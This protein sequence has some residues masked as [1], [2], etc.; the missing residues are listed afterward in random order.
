MGD[1]SESY[2]RPGR[3]RA[4]Q[5]ISQRASLL[6]PFL[7][8]AEQLPRPQTNHSSDRTGNIR[9]DKG[10]Q[11]HAVQF[12]QPDSRDTRQIPRN[13]IGDQGR[14]G[15]GSA[16]RWNDKQQD[17]SNNRYTIDLI[18]SLSSSPPPQIALSIIGGGIRHF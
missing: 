4:V 10:N 13:G 15:P 17:C 11:Q 9:D 8:P 12:Q 6:A 2:S 3:G 7:R 18:Y 1:S 5:A 14:R 16:S